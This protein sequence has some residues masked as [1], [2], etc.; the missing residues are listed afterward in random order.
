MEAHQRCALVDELNRQLLLRLAPEQISSSSFFNHPPRGLFC[1]TRLI[2]HGVVNG[3]P[4]HSPAVFLERS[5]P[6]LNLPR[7]RVRRNHGKLP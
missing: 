7:D 6:P 1:S 4:P 3:A 2:V 5:F